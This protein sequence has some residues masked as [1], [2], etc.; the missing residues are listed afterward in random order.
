MDKS[1]FNNGSPEQLAGIRK[2][3][4]AY[5]EAAAKGDSRIAKPF[6]TDNATISHVEN[7]TLISLPIKALFDYYDNDCPQP[8]SYDISVCNVSDDVAIVAIDSVFG[9]I[10][11]DDMFSLVKAGEDW[12]IVSKVFNVK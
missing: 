2:T 4:D 7:D 5:I 3:L 12:K 6:F 9:G 10:R 1:N 8:A 11:F